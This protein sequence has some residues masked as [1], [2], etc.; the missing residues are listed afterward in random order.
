MPATGAPA[1][2]ATADAVRPAPSYIPHRVSGPRRWWDWIL[3]ADPG[4]G[5]AQAGWRSLV[6]MSVGLAVSYGI[7]HAVGIPAMMGMLTGGMIALMSVFL[8]A[9]NTAPRLARAIL[10]L[11]IP[12][13][14]IVSL[15]AWLHP[16]RTLELSLTVVA[17]AL[18]FFL[19][20]YVP[21]FGLLTGAMLLPGFM[22]GLMA[23]IPLEDCGWICLIAVV[24]AVAVLVARLL[25]CYPTPREDLLRTQRAFLIEAHRV[26]DAAATAL[27]PD[28]D[29]ARAVHRMQRALRRLNIT[30]VTIDGRLAQPE[31]AA[32][33]DI[34]ELLHQYLF[35]AELALQGIGQAVGQMTGRHVPAQLR[36]TM[37]V[38]LVLARDAHLARSDALH[39]AAELI[40]RQAATTPEAMSANEAE[41]RALARRVAELLDAL[42]DALASWLNLGWNSPTARA[43]VPFQPTVALERNQPAGTGPA[44]QRV[45]DAHGGHGWRRVIPVL[46]VPLQAAVAAAITLPIAYAIDPDRFYWG[47]IGVLVGFFGS[48]TTPERLRRLGHRV[49]GTV[50][51]AVIGI[52]LVHLIGPGHIYWTMAVIVVGL[53]FG[54]WGL[55]FQYAYT[56]TGLVVALVQLYA[57]TAPYNQMDWLLTQRLIDNA[58]GMAVAAGC[59][60]VLFPVSTRKVARE[61]NRAY[62]SALEQLIAQVAVRWKEP[63]TPVRLRGS[64]R[65][66]DAALLQVDSVVRPLVRMP[67]SV[68]G[69]SGENLFA[70][71]ATATRHAHLLAAAADVNTDLAPALHAQMERITEVFADS[72]H[73]LDQQ[74]ATGKQGTWVRVSPII[75]ELRSAL[76]APAAPKADRLQI[77]LRELAA[78]DEVLASLADIRGLTITIPTAAAPPGVGATTALLDAVPTRKP[79][80]VS[81]RQAHAPLA[82]WATSFLR[83]P[84]GFTGPASHHSPPAASPRT[85]GGHTGPIHTRGDSQPARTHAP[86]G[87]T[88]TPR[89]SKNAGSTA[90]VSGTL[91]CPRHPDGCDAW[92]TV[93]SDRGKRHTKVKSAGGYYQITGLAPGRYTLVTSSA[94]HTPRAEFLLLDRP[95]RNLRHDITLQPTA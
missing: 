32:D 46:R 35:D 11:P 83:H 34:A 61:A 21:P 85:M 13:C 14:A 70:L 92:I 45:A 40:R 81:D 82:A 23:V 15:A 3:A 87:T 91:H 24:T 67:L 64:A 74:L 76:Q 33:P 57:L 89:S 65:A 38:A 1:S 56:V 58:L 66:L 48:N 60:A 47:L 8:V 88:T 69:R 71:L 84:N 37:V 10:W 16:Y 78:I 7:S 25:L 41:V 2:T 27:A 36:E 9:E 50:L 77:A 51:G 52:A 30:T 19:M 20:R 17:I 42:A 53:A 4:L 31:V 94:T 63:D 73:A 5:A 86:A 22:L 28:T 75:H 29:Q 62:L 79:A 90:T 12:F 72:L 59:A 68:R 49:V 43:R 26:V 18:L 93:V 6:S 44:A 55:Q 80:S 54:S 95:D 39:P